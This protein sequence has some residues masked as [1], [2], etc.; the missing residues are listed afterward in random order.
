MTIRFRLA[1]ILALFS[2]VLHAREDRNIFNMAYQSIENKSEV[3]KVGAEWFPYPEYADR[4]AWDALAGGNKEDILNQA[5]KYLRYKWQII[6]AYAYLDYEKTGNSSYETQIKENA[7]ALKS[8]IVGE[9]VEGQGR[10]MSQI[11]DGMY[12]FA[13]LQT[14]NGLSSAS[15][16]RVRQRMLPDPAFHLIALMSAE[17]GAAM[18]IS[19]HFFEE[20]FDKVDPLLGDIFYRAIES[21][22]LE[23]YVDEY[24]YLHGHEWLGF[25]RH[26]HGHR[27]NNWNTYCNTNVLLTFLLA[28]RNQERML[29]AMDISTKAMDNYL[30][31]NLL[32]GACDEGPSYWN[33]A[34]AKVYEYTQLMKEATAGKIDL[35]DDFQIRRIVEWKSKNYITDGWVVAF[36]D[37]EAH[38]NGD[39]H[40]LYRIGKNIGSKEMLD[41]GVSFAAKPDK[42]SFAN[43]IAISGEVYRTLESLRYFNEFTA[44]QQAALDEAGGDWDQM[45][46]DLRKAATSEFYNETEVAFLRTPNSWYIGVKG[47]NNKESHNHND[48]GSGVFFIE[49]CPVLIDPGVPTYDKKHFGPDRYKR[50]ITQSAWHNTPTLNGQMQAFGKEYKAVN[51]R[52]D[53]KKNIFSTDFAA[54][55]PAEAKCSEWVRTWSLKSSKLL[56]EDEF[57]FS[58]RVDETCIN[59]ITQ[60]PVYLPGEDVDGYVVKEG[61]LVI[62]A[63]NFDRTKVINVKMTYP[64]ELEPRKE[65]KEMTDKRLIKCWGKELNRVQLVVSKNAPLQGKYVYK[66]VRLK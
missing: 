4:A 21:H 36:A 8:L 24:R 51:T 65:T 53:V 42:K 15:R 20:E 11:I 3:F 14:W 63:R 39:R 12:F 16:D 37:G 64:K 13:N 5:R 10:Y 30:D 28:E 22:I 61:E 45:M 58:D 29:K 52:C 50:W 17:T 49:N 57:Q 7:R 34:G 35:L 32:D 60:G 19:L 40:I 44:A 62:A 9:L 31:Y 33:M 27:V 1:L 66:F 41:F 23:P 38:G 56:L 25:G 54:A 59:F 6:P 48:V 18:A 43:K 46:L 55:Y 47:G 2:V 26:T